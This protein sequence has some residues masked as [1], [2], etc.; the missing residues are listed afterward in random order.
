MKIMRA[1][2]K[3]NI[4]TGTVCDRAFSLNPAAPGYSVFV[5]NYLLL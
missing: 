4:P 2:M 1:L 3:L 5:A